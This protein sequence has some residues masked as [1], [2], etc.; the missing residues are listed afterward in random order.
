MWRPNG[1]HISY[2]LNRKVENKQKIFWKA[3]IGYV[4][5]WQ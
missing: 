3:E 2:K 1:R 4:D 5:L